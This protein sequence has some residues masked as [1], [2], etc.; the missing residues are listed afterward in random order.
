MH[1]ALTD[2]FNA[3]WT[4]RIHEEWIRNVLK[5]RPDLKREQLE[6]TRDLMDSRVREPRVE[7]YEHLIPKLDELPDP[8][9]AH[10][11]AAAIKSGADA[12]VTFNLKDFPKSV[13]S[14]YQIEAIHPDDFI[15][16][17]IDLDTATVCNAIKKLRARLKRPPMT[18]EQYLAIL[19]KQ[20]LPQ[21]VSAL[22]EFSELL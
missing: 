17:Q 16:Y 4:D 13:L 9:D 8:N 22:V 6:R 14:R 1:L 3:R 11:L 15:Q 7:N 19:K 5:N 12:I 20:S 18:V 10:V 2:M 21:S